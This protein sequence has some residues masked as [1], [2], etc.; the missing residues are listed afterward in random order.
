MLGHSHVSVTLGT[1][2][3]VLPQMQREAAKAMNVAPGA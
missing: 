2:S 1:Y 3:H